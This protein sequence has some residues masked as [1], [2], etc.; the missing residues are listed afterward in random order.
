MLIRLP[1]GIR[2]DSV[3][4]TRKTTRSLLRRFRS[5]ITPAVL[6]GLE[7]PVCS[8]M[9]LQ[10]PDSQARRLIVSQNV[11]SPIAEMVAPAIR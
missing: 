10:S 6:S 2:A 8:D 7:L 9:L 5:S 1:P 11:I 4:G 3:T